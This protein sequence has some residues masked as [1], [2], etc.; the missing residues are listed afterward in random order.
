MACALGLENELVGITHE[1]DYPAYVKSKPV[2]V[3]NVL[4][5]E[6]MPG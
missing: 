1:C 2:V 5:I 6:T 3:R 4:P